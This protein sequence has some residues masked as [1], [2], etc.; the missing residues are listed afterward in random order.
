MIE[1]IKSKVTPKHY[2]LIAAALGALSMFL[3]LTYSQVLTTGKYVLLGGDAWEIYIANIRML[4]RNITHGETLW[5]SFTTSM[6]YNTALTVAFE[7]MS[8]FNILFLIFQWVDPNIILAIII[9]SKVGLAAGAFQLFSS[10][11]LNNNAA[12]SIVFSIFYSMCAF[13]V[14]YCI[15]N[16]MW[17][18]GIYMLPIVA[19][20]TYVAVKKNKYLFLTLSYTYIFI[21]QFYMGYLLAGF[22]LILFFLLLFMQKKDERNTTIGSAIGKYILTAVLS[23]A[24]SAF[25]WVP[26]LTFLIHH[27]VSDSSQFIA[28][29]VSPFDLINNLFWGEFQDYHTYPYIYCGLPCLLL[30]PFYFTNKK[31]AAK[32]RVIGGV[33]LV[34]FMLGC[35]ILPIYKLFHA[36]DAP[37]MW[38][39]R[40]S[41]IISFLLCAIAVRQSMYLSDINKNML[42]GICAILLLLYCVEQRLQPMEIGWVAR[43]SNNGLIINCVFVTLWIVLSFALLRTKKR[44]FEILLLMLLVTVAETV[45]NGC[46]RTYD[47]N[48]KQGLTKEDY[49]YTWENEVNRNLDEINS[50]N[51]SEDL[52]GF[53]RICMYG[54]AIHNS[55]AY[56]G[57]NGITDFNSAEN[58]SL[59]YFMH[60]MGFYTTTRRTGGTGLT[61]PM[62][63]LLSVKNT[64]R[65]YIDMAMLGVN[66]DVKVYEN[67]YY[68][69]LAYMVNSEVADDFDYSGNV[70]EN[71]NELFRRLA[72][73]EGIYERVPDNMIEEKETG[74]MFSKEDKAFYATVPS[75]G[76][77]IFLVSG[78]ENEVYLEVES[79]NGGGDVSGLE[80]GTIMNQANGLD[81]KV[82]VPFA[83]QAVGA[84]E[85]H[86]FTLRTDDSFG[87]V[88]Q[89]NGLHFYSLNEEKLEEAYK[90]LSSGIMK[91]EDVKEGYIKGRVSASGEKNVLFTSIPYTDGWSVRLNGYNWEITPVCN[92]AFCAV[93]LPGEG[94]Y[95]IEMKYTCPGAARG[96][97]ITIAGI[98][99][100]V[101]TTL[102]QRPVKAKSTKSEM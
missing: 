93:I 14:E 77:L 56:F 39:Y 40:F 73:V 46:V 83:A 101:A 42:L 36:F 85:N 70:F 45:T 18:D 27:T 92:G 80:W 74:L 34:F 97:W 98:A 25:L 7:L 15:A 30:L 91:V 58:E 55:D 78:I 59:R 87:G 19:W 84:G 22:S 20:A 53:Y 89:T 26:V 8:P 33:L 28:L 95:E 3:M 65:L 96:L 66:T 48:W 1:K 16:F 17:L 13:S 47:S 99:L 75:G 38:N 32:E 94:E 88:Y 10:K 60:N 90:Y 51:A 79:V 76:E 43:N 102:S 37:D 5:Y 21:V 31:I 12:F 11:V 64:A 24:M 4:I 6:G 63:M 69:P 23:V 50:Q 41:F 62:E 35:M 61:K 68:L 81:S 44:R 52:Q 72:G 57:Y 82:S 67:P 2:W 100:F 9:I 86:M 71:Q 29:S 54:D 49:Y